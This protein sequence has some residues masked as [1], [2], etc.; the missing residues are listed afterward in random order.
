MRSFAKIW[1]GI[2][3]IAIGI[4]VTLMAI[5]FAAGVSIVDIARSGALSITRDS[6]NGW[7]I[8]R[9]TDDWDDDEYEAGDF[10]SS[11]TQTYEDIKAVDIDIAYGEVDIIQGDSF[12][13]DAIRLPRNGMEAS[14]TDGV[15]HIK[16]SGRYSSIGLFNSKRTPKITITIPKD[17]TA[18]YFNLDV[19]A[20]DVEVEQIFATEGKLNVSAGRMVI[21]ELNI[22]KS[23]SYTVGAGQMQLKNVTANN[24][25]A[26]CGVG[27]LVIKG[28]ITGDNDITCSVGKID[29][30]LIG[31]KKDYSYDI[32]VSIGNVVIDEE[33]YHNVSNKSIHNG[34]AANKFSL[35]CEIGNIAVDFD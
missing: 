35:N 16:E 11:F 26:N 12:S 10:N 14:V 4:G 27:E 15:W 28:S 18:E 9:A 2:A 17:F 8:S 29:M 5:T 31:T 19:D 20:G 30:D 23:S 25:T 13:I 24:I 6:E 34:T 1:A 3:L 21:H 22:S 7:V 33:S 32:S